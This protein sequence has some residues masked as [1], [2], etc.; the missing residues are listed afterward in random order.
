M[1]IYMYIYIYIYIIDIYQVYVC[2][3]VYI[4]IFIYTQI[5][6]NLYM[7]HYYSCVAIRD[8]SLK[9]HEGNDLDSPT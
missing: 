2:I 7:L 9:H 5:I 1:Y 4:H 8:I 6:N 3:Y